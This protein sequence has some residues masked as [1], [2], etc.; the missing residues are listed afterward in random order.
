MKSKHLKTKGTSMW[1][2]EKR[3]R[4]LHVFNIVFFSRKLEAVVD[5][6]LVICVYHR[7][8]YMI[9]NRVDLFWCM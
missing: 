7:I 9:D 3:K 2:G 6:A 5:W 8:G 4:V 1:P